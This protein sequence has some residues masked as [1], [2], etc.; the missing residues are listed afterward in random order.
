MA[1][2]TQRGI[3][4]LLFVLIVA[5]L[6]AGTAI[7]L[8]GLATIESRP[9]LDDTVAASDMALAWTARV[10]L[11]L[12]LIWLAIGA[13]ATRTTLVRRPGAAAAR[14][15][16]LSS[17]RPWRARESMLGLLPLDRALMMIVPAGVLLSARLI[18]VSFIDM[19]PALVLM[20]TITIFV[21]VMVVLVRPRSPW[22][23]IAAVG[24]VVML[25][26][27]LELLGYAIAGPYGYWQWLWQ[28]STPIRVVVLTMMF[29]LIGW[30]IVAACG[31]ASSQV[32]ARRATG[33]AVG[34]TGA[35]LAVVGALT[36]GGGTV[37]EGTLWRDEIVTVS[38]PSALVWV[39]VAI[40]VV[41]AVVGTVIARSPHADDHLTAAG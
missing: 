2:G 39:V 37:L 15:T 6:A 18:Q 26:G 22:P 5:A 33:A 4:A 29:G 17:T 40:G 16:W 7:A 14:A 20:A 21:A 19:W 31:A 1:T 11:V 34:A 38:F 23:V 35:A 8:G 27:A 28:S 32:G 12:A 10:L 41:C 36:L 30:A 25:Q 24:G 13:I 9:V 3:R